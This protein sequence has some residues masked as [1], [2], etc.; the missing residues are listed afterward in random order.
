MLRYE[1]SQYD[2]R[3]QSHRQRG[4]IEKTVG[5]ISDPSVGDQARR[6]V[7]LNCWRIPDCPA[8]DICLHQIGFFIQWVHTQ[9]ILAVD[10]F[11]LVYI[12]MR[13]K[14]LDAIKHRTCSL[15]YL[16]LFN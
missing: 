1:H 16:N 12:I 8:V 14:K 6:H 7:H 13:L 15:I 5:V 3:L 4:E 9:T 11:I 10:N 2:D